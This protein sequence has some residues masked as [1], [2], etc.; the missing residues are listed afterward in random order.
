MVID[1]LNPRA[2]DAVVMPKPVI[3]I[4]SGLASFLILVGVFYYIS[5]P[6]LHLSVFK[7]NPDA[8]RAI[9]PIFW[10]IIFGVPAALSA[11][12]IRLVYD[13]LYGRRR[14]R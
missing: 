1:A 12:V 5:I 7:D 14:R 2:Y 10:I 6:V 4:L 11:G 9:N 13:I 3:L 8:Q